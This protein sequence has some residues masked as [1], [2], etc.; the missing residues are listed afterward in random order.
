MLQTDRQ[1]NDMQSHDR[2]LHYSALRGKN[3]PFQLPA[4][5]L[6]PLSTELREYRHKETLY[7]TK[8]NDLLNENSSN[9]TMHNNTCISVV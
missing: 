3:I 2:A 6:T 4:V 9:K 7:W 8:N 5:V 1:T